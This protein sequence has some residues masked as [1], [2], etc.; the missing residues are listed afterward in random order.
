MIHEGTECNFFV[1]NDE[2]KQHEKNLITYA[3]RGMEPMRGFP[4]F[5]DGTVEFMKSNKKG[6]SVEIAGQDKVFYG[7]KGKISYKKKAQIQIDKNGLT[8]DIIFRGRLEKKDY[9]RLLKRSHIHCY[10]TKEFVPSWSL[11]DAM[12]TG[13]LLVVNRTASVREILPEK[14][15]IWV[16]EISKD[17]IYNGLITA[18]KML[19]EEPDKV[20][21]M[22]TRCRQNALE[23]FDRKTSLERWF[24]LFQ[25]RS[26]KKDI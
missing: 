25:H 17:A 6:F 21:T 26:R 11:I 5:I 3:T 12:S 2:W 4:E 9:A 22:R 20:D 1:R 15:V 7:Q 23:K 14:G 24:S 18:M 10:F 19:K 13:C 8:Q 16:E